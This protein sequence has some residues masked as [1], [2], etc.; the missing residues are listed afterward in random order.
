MIKSFFRKQ[1][2]YLNF[3]YSYLRWRLFVLVILSIC[4]GFL[5]G[6]GLSMFIPLMKYVSS[7]DA[8]SQN[9]DMGGLDFVLDFIYGIGFTPTLS[10]ILFFM[11]FFFSLKGLFTWIKLY[12]GVIFRQNFVKN[13]RVQN[14]DYF[15]RFKYVGYS[16]VSPGLIQ[17][18]LTSE[19]SAVVNAYVNY[20]NIIQMMF[21]ILTYGFLAVLSDPL[22]ALMVLAGGIGVSFLFKLIYKRTKVLSRKIVKLNSDFHGQLL[23]FVSYF[24]YLKATDRIFDYKKILIKKVHQIEGNQREMGSLAS[25]VSAIR[26][27][28][29][30]ALVVGV[31]QIQ[32][33]FGLT[34]LATILISLLLFY[35]AM[36]SVMQ[37]Q[38]LYNK[39]LGCS[40]SIDNIQEF[41]ALL[42]KNLDRELPFEDTI[43]IDEIR[44]FNVTLQFPDG[45]L[46]LKGIDLE[47][48]KNRSL[49]VVGESG[50]G[51]TSL[52]NVI[53]GL[54]APTKGEI[55]VNNKRVEAK[56]G[57][58]IPGV[59]IGYVT[60]E[61]I[62]FSDTI[63]NNVS[64]WDEPSE[65]N[66]ERCRRALD[67]AYALHFV[68]ELKDG[69]IT[70]LDNNG[71]ALSGGQKQRLSIARELYRQV[72]L[73]ILDEATSALDSET[74]NVI[75]KSI[76]EL[77]GSL[78]II[79]IAHRLSTIKEVDDVAVLKKGKLIAHGE[80]ESVLQTSNEFE[81]MIHNQRIR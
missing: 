15:S 67:K 62:I 76:D 38:N 75:K 48:K 40:G 52:V 18:A 60:Q 77:Q 58:R 24:K 27:P 72:D 51:K 41:T 10:V 42:Q 17:N 4:V 79:I 44:L 22:F 47:I 30:I 43:A 35:R 21:L 6:I 80:F 5:D 50:S 11:L 59:K 57:G 68:N 73:L 64:F 2:P 32:L 3:F 46:G 70:F 61:P 16:K 36:A 81:Q 31:I 78:T 9:V 23:Q 7:E 56:S 45:T 8:A 1:F 65:V 39:F 66:L 34:S 29:M 71:I 53:S 69:L 63:F 49:A 55:L 37:V 74:E 19:I 14:I 20:T 33:G 13:L 28:L 54:I 25:L 26:E 12:L